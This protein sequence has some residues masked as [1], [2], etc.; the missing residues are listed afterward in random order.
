MYG[1][2]YYHFRLNIDNDELMRVY[3]GSAK[4]LRVRTAEGPVVDLDANHLR[5][6]TTRSGIFGDFRLVVTM[7]NKFVKIE[8]LA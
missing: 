1:Q 2:K 8:R 7:Q 3:T 6:F 5:Q 4:R